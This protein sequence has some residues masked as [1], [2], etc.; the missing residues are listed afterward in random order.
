[1]Q[2]CGCFS[3]CADDRLPL[4][5]PLRVSSA[6][7]SHTLGAAPAHSPCP[8]HAGAS[9]GS[10]APPCMPQ[11][12]SHHRTA[13]AASPPASPEAMPPY[14]GASSAS[15]PGQRPLIS[16]T[17]RTAAPLLLRCHPCLTAPQSAHTAPPQ[18]APLARS[19]AAWYRG[20][21]R[22]QQR[23]TKLQQCSGTMLYCPPTG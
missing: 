12:T 8:T 18:A 14:L 13:P 5:P 20:A 7:C 17:M 22:S 19:G 16:P 11:L 9:N 1:M 3:C 10:A 21:Y 6:A 4:V 23:S 2:H 15:Q